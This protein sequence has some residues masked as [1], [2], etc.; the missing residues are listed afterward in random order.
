MSQC[1]SFT[2]N[3]IMGLLGQYRWQLH[4]QRGSH[5]QF[6]HPVLPGRIT[7]ERHASK[8][9]PIEIVKSTFKQAGMERFYRMFQQGEP[10]KDVKKAIQ[11]EARQRF[12]APQPAAAVPA[13]S[14][15]PDIS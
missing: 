12:D 15:R 6:T 3:D 8:D 4:E 9:L 7:V 5:A 2:A 13:S 1:R 14:P 11:A 10:F